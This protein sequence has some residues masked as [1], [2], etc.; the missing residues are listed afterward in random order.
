[1]QH[2]NFTT[3]I[4]LKS[5]MPVVTMILG[6]TIQRKR[7]SIAEIFAVLVLTV[8]LTV[9]LMGDELSL[10]EGSTMGLFCVT[11]SLI[12]AALTPIWQ[13]HL[14]ET[15]NAS[16]SEMLLHLYTGSFVISLVLTFVF[17]EMS[18]G[19]EVLRTTST[20]FN[21]LALFC[22][23]TFA[24]LGT[25]SSIGIIT[26]YGSLTNGICNSARKVL[27]I[28]ISIILFPTR[29][30]VTMTQLFGI[31]LFAGGLFLR[32]TAKKVNVAAM[33][34]QGSAGLSP[35]TDKQKL[36]YKRDVLAQTEASY[37]WSSMTN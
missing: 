16:T 14:N 11:I 36:H 30:G 15:Y 21:M 34:D 26:R 10:P 2:I 8:G 5:A 29:N 27:S 12:S 24:F 37:K 7:Y 22:F 4:I 13:E 33:P 9:F 28:L 3:K 35:T 1:M 18:A 31:S 25:N 23:C 20:P 6:F 19:I 17:D 32:S